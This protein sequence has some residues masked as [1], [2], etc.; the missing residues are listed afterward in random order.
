MHLDRRAVGRFAHP[1]IQILALARLEEE[2]IV[3]VVELR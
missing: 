1:E 2:Y 3:A